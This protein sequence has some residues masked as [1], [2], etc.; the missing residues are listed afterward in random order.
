MK[1][2]HLHK[3]HAPHTPVPRELSFDERCRFMGR[4]D[5]LASAVKSLA[6]EIYGGHYLT[7]CDERELAETYIEALTRTL[8]RA[9]EF[10]PEH[11]KE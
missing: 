4:I 8:H 9:I 5:A 6:G 10:T 11:L 3:H 2:E 7:N 1:V